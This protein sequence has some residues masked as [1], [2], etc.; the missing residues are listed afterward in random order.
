MLVYANSPLVQTMD[1]RRIGPYLLDEINRSQGHYEKLF[2]SPLD[3]TY[4]TTSGGNTGLG[5]LASFDDTDPDSRPRKLTQRKYWK[6][7]VGANDGPKARVYVSDPIISYSTGVSQVVVAA[8]IVTADQ[9]LLGMVG[10]TLQWIQIK[11]RINAIREDILRDIGRFAN[12]CLVSHNGVYIY[13]WDPDKAVRVKL[14]RQG[15]PVIN[16][17]GEK[18]V[19]KRK[20]T[21]E[22]APGLVRAGLEMVKGG[23]GFNFYLD[24][25]TGQE[26]AIVYAPVKSAFY[27]MALVLP[28]KRILAPVYRL[29]ETYLFISLVSIFLALGVSWLISRKVSNPI[30]TLS[31]AVRRL[32]RGGG[33]A[34]SDPQAA[35]KSGS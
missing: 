16:G 21:G 6:F 34:E 25:D 12:L 26:M 4:Y 8:S 28:K 33:K 27:S 30:I 24:P 35:P 32:A 31:K 14:D 9:R 29:R 11:K 15:K 7:V 10:G 19:V 20:I 5:G 2:L 18:E 17:N 1:W 13:H 23:E 3:G 22:T